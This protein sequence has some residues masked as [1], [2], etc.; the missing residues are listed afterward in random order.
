ML[1]RKNMDELIE[2]PLGDDEIA[3]THACTCNPRKLPHYPSDWCFHSL[4]AFYIAPLIRLHRTP[5]NCGHTYSRSSSDGSLNIS[6]PLQPSPC[7][8]QTLHTLN[9]GLVVANP[10]AQLCEGILQTLNTNSDVPNMKFPDQ[11]LL[12][13]HFRGKVRFLGYEYNALK[14]LREC[15]TKLWRDD[16]V[17][18][19]MGRGK[20]HLQGYA[21]A[22]IALRPL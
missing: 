9:S 13:L 19:T 7:A 10:S 15:H 16:E 12:S 18:I 5:Q 14:T 22:S 17:C 8:S 1:V 2:M 4:G 21:C 20:L 11:D 3:A 6:V